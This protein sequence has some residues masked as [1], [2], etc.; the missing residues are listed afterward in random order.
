MRKHALKIFI[1]I[2]CLI[3]ISFASLAE[4]LSYKFIDIHR[5]DKLPYTVPKGSHTIEINSIRYAVDFPYLK[6]F[7]PNS[8]AYIFQKNSDVN[9][10]IVSTSDAK[11][12]LNHSYTG[13]GYTRGAIFVAEGTDFSSEIISIH[14]RKNDNKK[15]FG[16][17]SLYSNPN[18][19]KTHPSFFLIT[20]QGDY[21]LDVFAGKREAQTASEI[22]IPKNLLEFQENWKEIKKESFIKPEQSYLPLGDDSIVLLVAENVDD[23][24]T[25]IILYARKR[26]ISYSNCELQYV[27]KLPMDNKKSHNKIVSYKGLKDIVLYAQNDKLWANNKYEN[28]FSSK[29]RPFRDG[30][31]GPT[32][33]ANGLA[34]ILDKKDLPKINKISKDG[35]GFMFYNNSVNDNYNND[36]LLPYKLETEDEFFRYFPLAVAGVSTGNNTWR[37]CGRSEKYGS[38]LTYL[39]NLCNIFGVKYYKESNRDKVIEKIKADNTVAIATVTSRPFT[40]RSHYLVLLGADDEYLYVID[41]FR[42]ENYD[43]NGYNGILNVITPGLVAIKLEDVPRCSFKSIYIMQKE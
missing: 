41:S 24:G 21:R 1:S 22:I 29:K 2:I 16:S 11:F 20:P 3:F 30:G 34:N 43:K 42:R 28:C 9:Q 19:Y 40:S 14:G 39:N 17:L 33:V 23:I 37:I 7:A 15:I 13:R 25:R 31:C 5:E 8:V 36:E 10:P 32:A 4:G 12:Y 26:P 27:N 6:S 18:Y 35:Q 38:R